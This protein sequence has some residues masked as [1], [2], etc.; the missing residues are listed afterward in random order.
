MNDAT[1]INHDFDYLAEDAKKEFQWNV[2]SIL[3]LEALISLR[4]SEAQV[5]NEDGVFFTNAELEVFTEWLLETASSL[6]VNYSTI[7]R[8]NRITN[9]LY[10]VAMRIS[11]SLRHR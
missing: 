5:M 3:E 10:H 11:D 4:S 1:N 8:T 9:K 2:N 6:L 7:D